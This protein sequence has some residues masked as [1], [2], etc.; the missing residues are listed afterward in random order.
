MLNHSPRA[1]PPPR[2]GLGSITLDCRGAFNVIVKTAIHATA[3]LHSLTEASKSLTARRSAYFSRFLARRI[4]ILLKII[5]RSRYTR[6]P[7]R[8]AGITPPLREQ[9]DQLQSRELTRSVVADIACPENAFQVDAECG[10]N[11][12]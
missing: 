1:P 5:S 9:Y 12:I 2:P 3:H 7:S 6:M 10:P 11:G 8:A 4:Q